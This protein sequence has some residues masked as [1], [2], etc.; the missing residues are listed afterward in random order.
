MTAAPSRVPLAA[1]LAAGPVVLDGGLATLLEAHGADLTSSLWSARLL[2]DDPA[3]VGAAHREYFAAGAQVAISASY[4]ASFEG[5][6]GLGL[7]R[8]EAATLMIRSIE[9]ARTARDVACP[10]GW[11]A[12]SVGP[13]GAVLADGSEYRGDDGLGVARLRDWHRPRLDVLR[14]AGADVLAVETIPSLAEATAVVSAIAGT[15]HPAWLSMTVDGDRTRAGEPLDEVFAMAAEVPEVI[16][17]GVNC[18]A[19]EH[20]AAAVAIAARYRPVVVYPNS[21]QGWDAAHRCWTG[22]AAFDAG[23]VRDWIDAGA[24]LIGGCC[25][26]GPAEIRQIAELSRP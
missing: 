24:R 23:Q 11:V 20:V 2:R 3:A 13:Y 9:I 15:G 10:D 6:A 7:D 5:F 14:A 19:P 21:G 18:T 16:A 17:L 1:A 8:D 12:A 25:R 4:Q 22:S 26:I